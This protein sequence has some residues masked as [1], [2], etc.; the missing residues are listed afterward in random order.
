MSQNNANYNEVTTKLTFQGQSLLFGTCIQGQN[1]CVTFHEI[2][3]GH[4][5][6]FFLFL[7]SFPLV[8][9]IFDILEN[10]GL[11]VEV[12]ALVLVQ[13][14]TQSDRRVNCILPTRKFLFQVAFLEDGRGIFRNER[15]TFPLQQVIVFISRKL[16]WVPLKFMKRLMN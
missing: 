8:L 1:L 16:A 9:K 14:I 11:Y 6:P 4:H 13:F 5:R 2:K 15:G 3:P 12:E 7:K 10:G